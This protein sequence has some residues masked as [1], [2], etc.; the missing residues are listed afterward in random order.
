[1][2][3]SYLQSNSLKKQKNPLGLLGFKHQERCWVNISCSFSLNPHNFVELF[4]HQTTAYSR[5]SKYGHIIAEL[6]QCTT[7]WYTKKSPAPKHMAGDLNG[8][9]R[10]NLLYFHLIVLW[11]RN[12][13]E[14]TRQQLELQRRKGEKIGWIAFILDAKML[15]NYKRHERKYT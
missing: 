11:C 10:C 2:A 15:Y 1:M 7:D 14:R 6:I 13:W 4:K 3:S 9:V 5:K 8:Y 12:Q